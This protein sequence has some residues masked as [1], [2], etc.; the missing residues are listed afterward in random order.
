MK[1]T[2]KT[3]F[4]KILRSSAAP[5][6]LIVLLSIVLHAMSLPIATVQGDARAE[7][8]TESGLPYLSEMDSYLYAR[9]TEDLAEEG[10]SAYT[11]RHDRGADP[12]ISANATGEE[13]DVVMGLPILGATVY[14]LLSWIPGVTPYGVI[15]WLAPIITSLTAIPAYI[16]VKRRT[17]RLGGLVAGLLVAVAAPF[18]GHTHAGFYDTDLGLSLLPCLFLLCFAEALLTRDLKKQL[19]WAAGSGVSLCLLGTFWRAYYAY[20]CIGAAAAFAAGMACHVG[21]LII[22]LRARR[23][24]SAGKST[25]PLRASYVWR[26]AGL[27][28]LAQALLCLLVRGKEFFTDIGGIVGNV[29]GTLAN[30][31]AA[32]PDAA[33]FVGELQPTPLLSNE[34]STGLFARVLDG[35]AAYTDGVINLLGGWTVLLFGLGVAALLVVLCLR[36]VFGRE[37]LAGASQPAPAK[38]FLT[39]PQSLLVTSA[40]L[41]TWLACGL[42]IVAKGTR[43]LT[44]PVLPIGILCGIGVGLLS[45]RLR[46]FVEQSETTDD[47][48]AKKPRAVYIALLAVA[49]VTFALAVRAEFGNLACGIIGGAILVLGLCLYRLRCEALL[50][51]FA[52]ALVLSPCMAAFGFAFCNR[53][54]GSDTLHG[55]SAYIAENTPANAVIA[56]WWDYG[57]YYE[58]AAKRLTLGDG[59][60]FNSEWNYWLGQALMTDDDRLAQGI[61]GMLATGGLDA[62]HKLMTLYRT[63]R[64]IPP[65]ADELPETM[66][67][68]RL[69]EDVRP[70]AYAT[71]VLK[72]ILHYS[73]E[74]GSKL[75]REYYGL[76]EADAAEIIRLAY[77]PAL[78]PIYLVISDDMIRKIGAIATYGNWGFDGEPAIPHI[79]QG[80]T[81]RTVAPGMTVTFPLADSDYTVQVTRGADG[82]LTATFLN[83]TGQALASELRVDVRNKDDYPG[84]TGYVMDPHTMDFIPYEF[85][86]PRWVS[87]AKAPYTI[88]LR[89]D[90]EN[91]FRCLVCNTSAAN[92]VLIRSIMGQGDTLYNNPLVYRTTIELPGADGT[93]EW[94][95]VSVWNIVR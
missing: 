40:F 66:P 44:I 1:T 71:A 74:Q 95:E 80:M 32:F 93:P 21:L 88:Y 83:G 92:S 42:V 8:Q 9:L 17:N 35:F 12:Y 87:P 78:R 37:T 14:K 62:T 94:H 61:F 15:Y 65:A 76:D 16:F 69:S 46:K 36:T 10:F 30:G 47:K 41:F 86:L 73:R 89:E 57:Y 85:P 91:E 50:N 63:G 68:G 59:G 23:K 49:V 43:F 13:G 58:Y 53:P 28:L 52:V 45:A 56:S 60:N 77:D 54:D 72:H 31:D 24:P 25:L 39:L 84:T 2:F 33:R 48:L 81:A 18:A 22:V 34:Y 79:W 27:T 82:L 6:V 38:T 20:F 51:L 75:L 67:L 26:G 3:R 55:A 4:Q 29:S 5:C 19:A 64:S 11:L 70:A 7:Y 90:S